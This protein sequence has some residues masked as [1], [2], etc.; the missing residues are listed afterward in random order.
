[1][2]CGNPHPSTEFYFP[3]I[4]YDPN[5]RHDRLHHGVLIVGYGSE[6]TEMNNRSYWIV[7]NRYKSQKYLNFKIEKGILFGISVWTQI[8]KPLSTLVK[9]QKPRTPLR[10]NTDIFMWWQ[11]KDTVSSLLGSY[12]HVSTLEILLILK[13][14]GPKSFFYLC[15]HLQSVKGFG[16]EFYAGLE[17][18]N[19]QEQPLL[20][21]PESVVASDVLLSIRCYCP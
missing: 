4:Y 15:L 19:E 12:H 18:N 7:K 6:G 5:C 2:S 13:Y 14:I 9:S 21:L 1:M 8:L 16:I 3:G 11:H 10:V 20:I 17:L